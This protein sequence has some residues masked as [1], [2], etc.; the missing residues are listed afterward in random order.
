MKPFHN[1]MNELW[2]TIYTNGLGACKKSGGQVNPNECL[3]ILV[4]DALVDLQKIFISVHML[5]DVSF[6]RACMVTHLS[7]SIARMSLAPG[8]HFPMVYQ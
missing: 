5:S 7:L 2:G 3:P 1:D 6:Q 4:T 8:M